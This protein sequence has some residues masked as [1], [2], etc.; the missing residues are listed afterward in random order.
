L[1][2]VLR[3][4]PSVADPRVLVSAA[5]RDDAAVFKLTDDRAIVATLDFFTP[6][7]DDPYAFGAIAAANA[8]SDVYAMGGKPLIALNLVAWPRDPA[9]LELLAET[10]RGGSDVATRAGALVLGGHSVDDPE[11]KYGMVAIGEA[12]PDEIRT[13]AGAQ[14]GDA[15][16]LTKPI[17]TGVLSTALKRGTIEEEEMA[18]AIRA[19]STLNADAADAM[20]G[21]GSAVH[22][23]TD[24][25]GFGLL[26]HLRNIVAASHRR[27]RIRAE[28]VPVFE[29]VI[30][31]IEGGFV[32]GGT[33]RN[34]EQ[35]NEFTTW[36]SAVSATMR[37]LVCDAQTSGG[38]LIAVDPRRADDL[39]A[40]L[41]K[42][43]TPAAAVIGVI[44]AGDGIVVET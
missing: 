33:K 14:V 40:E 39:V 15:L 31:L 43:Q 22:A 7:V 16:V 17:G 19:M 37:T 44:E 36:G 12:H 41:R 9:M 27:A 5:T 4:V 21:L 18:E 2:Q 32:P 38:M 35:A 28:S 20:R 11:P 10:L 42:R 13:V 25:T 23:A 34:E 1:T 29:R 26:G 30:A 24:V 8:F 3:H 6:I